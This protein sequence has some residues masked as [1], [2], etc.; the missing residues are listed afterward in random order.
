MTILTEIKIE[1][2]FAF[3]SNPNNWITLAAMALHILPY[4]LSWLNYQFDSVCRVMSSDL[5]LVLVVLSS[6]VTVLTHAEVNTISANEAST[7]DGSHVAANTFVI[8]VSRK[9]VGKKR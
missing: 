8:I 4:L 7:D 3:V 9:T 2:V 5:K 1:T 6:E